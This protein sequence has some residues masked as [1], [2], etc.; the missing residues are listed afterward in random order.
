MQ[1][2]EERPGKLMRLARVEVR[3]TLMNERP[4]YRFCI[5]S[6]ILVLFAASSLAVGPPLKI[7]GG[8]V[9]AVPP[10]SSDSVAYMTIQNVSGRTLHLTS[11]STPAAETVVPMETT[12]LT[13]DDRQLKGMKPVSKLEIPA[14][15]Q[16]VLDP[17][18][19]HLMLMHL[20]QPLRP[21]EKVK[22]TLRFQP[23]NMV[24]TKDLLVAFR[25]P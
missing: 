20:K 16:L 6:A 7:D 11:A 25:K 3:F 21:G 1:L 2:F 23:G 24:V 12:S 4:N 22:L 9:Q 19:A 10:V 15:G 17:S 5:A 14:H 18:G 13:R 8:W